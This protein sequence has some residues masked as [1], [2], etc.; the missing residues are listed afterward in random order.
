MSGDLRVDPSVTIPGSELRWRF[1][2]ATPADGRLASAPGDESA[3]AELRFNLVATTA[4]PEPLKARALGRLRS[5]LVNGELIVLA[6]AHRTRSQ[7]QR[8]AGAKLAAILSRAMAAPR[9]GNGGL[10]PLP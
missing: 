7:N 2:P 6:S 1:S 9:G 3:K 5:S 4:I 10:H 8:A